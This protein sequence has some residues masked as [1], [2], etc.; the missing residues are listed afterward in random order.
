MSSEEETRA[1]HRKELKELQAQLTGLRKQA[2]SDK[3]RKKELLDE[4]SRLEQA[5]KQRHEQELAGLAPPPSAAADPT[6]AAAADSDEPRPEASGGKSKKAKQALR[7]ERKAAEE[8]ELR[9]QAEEEAR[10]MPNKQ[11][12]EMH[13]LTAALSQL[14]LE[15][16]PVKA[17]GHCMYNAVADQLDHLGV[18]VTFDN[19]YQTLRQQTARYMRSHKDD[20]MP[21]MVDEKTGDV[22]T[23]EAWDQYCDDLERKAMWGGQHELR[24][25]SQVLK[26]PITVHQQDSPAVLMGEDYAGSPIML[27]YHRHLYGLG[28]HYNSV[29][30]RTQQQQQ[31]QQQ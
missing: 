23:E 2:Q 7:K 16:H 9:R 13:A 31:Q 3:K 6:P 30:K 25:L 29:R 21:F 17:D 27:S 26:R 14:D 12:I 20:F 19:N 1:R 18:P 22:M 15:I 8:E 10:N 4:I 24:A 11:E 5:T 28:E